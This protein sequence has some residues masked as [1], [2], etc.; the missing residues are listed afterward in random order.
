LLQHAFRSTSR[1]PLASTPNASGFPRYFRSLA[2]HETERT[3]CSPPLL[4]HLP[5][6][7][8]VSRAHCVLVVSSL[9]PSSFGYHSFIHSLILTFIPFLGLFVR[10]TIILILDHPGACIGPNARSKESDS[11][12]PLRNIE[13]TTVQFHS[14]Q[15]NLIFVV[16][17]TGAMRSAPD[18]NR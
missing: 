1:D 13:P 2:A 17:Y 6:C 8:S 7:T 18:F 5:I 3:L 9:S 15:S 4:Q 16:R 10:F 11:A 14:N 12:I